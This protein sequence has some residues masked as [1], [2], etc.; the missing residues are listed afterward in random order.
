MEHRNSTVLSNSGALRD[1]AR[2][3]GI[4][5][6]VAH[7]YF[8]SWNMER[9]RS[10]AIE[11]FNFEEANV[12]G[13]LWLGEGF[14]SYYDDL[15]MQRSGLSTLDQTLSSLA[16]AIN[17]V[18][19]SPAR[20]IRSA[21]EMSQ[22]AP[23]N[24]AAA[25][26]D[27]TNWPN[28]FISYYTWGEAIGLGLDLTLRDRS[29][30]KVGARRFHACLVDRDLDAPDNKSQAWSRRRTRWTTSKRR[31][32]RSPAIVRLQTI[33]SRDTSRA[34]TSLTTLACSRAPVLP[35]APIAAGQAF[36]VGSESFNFAGSAGAELTTPS[37]FGSALYKAGVAQ[38]DHITALDGVKLTSRESLSE[39]LRRH[40]PGD[41][42][43]IR[44]VRRSGDA[45]SAMLTLEENARIGIV[46]VEQS[47][48]TITA[49]QKRFR[50]AWLG[51]KVTRK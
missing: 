24:D 19:L 11:P 16:N 25:A 39:V 18:T 37:R 22:L 27:R 15:I 9:I 40:K 29:N 7:E 48:G 30:G 23:F 2:R 21:E 13:E 3:A 5:G 49:E 6:T 26:I 4:L 8:H 14:T 45:V 35:R 47:G 1:P 17:T 33:F 32:E 34:T 50:E 38:D 46:P 28:T 43:P 36:I 10:R 20:Q 44:F 31:S 51:S 42:V 41:I 12:S